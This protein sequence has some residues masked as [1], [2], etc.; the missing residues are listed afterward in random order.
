MI[1]ILLIDDDE[2]EFRLIKRM[3]E[4]CFH[5]PYQLRYA[6]TLEKA[7]SILKNDKID[8]ILLDDK[9][10]TGRTAKSTVPML[11]NISD[12]IPMIVIS[13]V[14]DAAYLKDK[15]IL[16]VYDIVDKYK[17]RE[18]IANGMLSALK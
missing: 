15:T 12:S 8:V 5:E 2:T 3:L 16:N 1:N 6:N 4:D 10:G 14:I 17:L 9:L 13:S 11:Q 7:A 18:K